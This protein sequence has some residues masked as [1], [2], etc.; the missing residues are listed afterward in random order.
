MVN[1]MNIYVK[2]NNQIS[3]F[4]MTCNNDSRSY[5]FPIFIL[6]LFVKFLLAIKTDCMQHIG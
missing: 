1:Y 6:L 2:Y 3:L 4:L 5:L